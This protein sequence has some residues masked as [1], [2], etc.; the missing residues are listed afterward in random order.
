MKNTN[1][2]QPLNIVTAFLAVLFFLVGFFTMGSFKNTGDACYVAKDTQIVYQ[3]EL[4]E[5][6]NYL[7]EIYLNVG[8][9]YA[10]RGSEEAVLTVKT[11]TSSTSTSDSTWT[12]LNTFSLTQ[13]GIKGEEG[14]FNFATIAKDMKKGSSVVRRVAFTS[15]VSFE[16]NELAFIAD[17]GEMIKVKVAEYGNEGLEKDYLTTLENAFD[18]QKSF[19][20]KTSAYRKFTQEEGTY[21]SYL[22]N[23]SMGSGYYEEDAYIF[24]EDFGALAVLAIAPSVLAFGESVFA[25]RLPSLMATTA[26]MVGIALLFT[27]L[28]K[29][30]K[31]GFVASCLFAFGGLAWTSGRLGAPYAFVTCAL[32]YAV[33]FAYRFFAKGVAEQR[34]TRGLGNLF[35]AGFCASVAVAMEGLAI[36]PVLGIVAL[37]VFGF[38]R[39]KKAFDYTVEKLDRVEDEERRAK[40]VKKETLAYKNKF[41]ACL[42]YSIFGFVVTYFFCI[43]ISTVICHNAYVRAYGNAGF[44]TLLW[45]NMFAGFSVNAVTAVA[46]AGKAISL[47]WFLPLKA[48]VVYVGGGAW[49]LAIA[50]PVLTLLAFAGL[51]VSTVYFVKNF[52]ATDKKNNRVRRVYFVV[53]GGTLLTMLSALIKG[54]NQTTGALTFYAFYYGFIL[55]AWYAYS[56]SDKEETETTENAEDTQTETACKCCKCC[57]VCK[58]GVIVALALT[59]ICFILAIP[60]MFGFASFE[61]WTKLIGWLTIL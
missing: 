51:V 29:D 40:L 56:K 54:V 10:V 59:A 19:S 13:S 16:L 12:T 50:N 23:L 48:A 26:T 20:A 57:K 33:Y 31:Y 44:A 4:G 58:I 25:L 17:N 52:K 34:F 2:K 5:K 55:L 60:A 24:A 47:A 30:E 61:I 15:T 27:L 49:W 3:L 28:F 32:V 7:K 36:L 11:S 6:Q 18:A 43:F 21:L 1:K 22:R 42:G 14:L 46:E 38:L 41:R 35:G 9:V 39:Q 37:L 45:K 8:S 53:L